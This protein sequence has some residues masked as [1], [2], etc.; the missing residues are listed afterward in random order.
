MTWWIVFSF[1][2]GSAV[3]A[4]PEN[5]WTRFRG[6]NGTGISKAKTIP[7]KWTAKDYNWIVKLSGTGSS[8]PVLWK[9]QLFLT[10]NDLKKMTLPCG[11]TWFG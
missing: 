9:K 4:E 10:C 8:S 11:V 7:T 2:I 1:T 5:E 6:P 3:A